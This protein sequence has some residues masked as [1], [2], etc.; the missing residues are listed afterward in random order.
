MKRFP[1][2]RRV[3]NAKV[4][5]QTVT[6]FGLNLQKGACLAN[7]AAKDGKDVP[8]RNDAYLQRLFIFRTVR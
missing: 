7:A 5:G 3:E 8:L 2:A 1:H 6:S 4:K